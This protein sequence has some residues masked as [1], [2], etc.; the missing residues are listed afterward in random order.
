MKY[1]THQASIQY[2]DFD[3]PKEIEKQTPSVKYRR[4]VIGDG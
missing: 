4:W 1:I 2:F 3:K